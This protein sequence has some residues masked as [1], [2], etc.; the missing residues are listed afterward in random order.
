M[1]KILAFFSL[2]WLSVSVFAQQAQ[3]TGQVEGKQLYTLV[4]VYQFAPNSSMDFV[5]T[6]TMSPDGQFAFTADVPKSEIFVM[7]FTDGVR[8][9]RQQVMVLHP[10]DQLTMR[11]TSTY[12]G[13][14]LTEVKGSAEAAF[15]L[16]YQKQVKVFDEAMKG[17][18]DEFTNALTDLGRKAIQRDVEKFY[19][20]FQQ[21]IQQTL[22]TYA[23]C[24]GAVF[25]GLTE[26]GRSFDANKEM[27]TTLYNGTKDQYGYHPLLAELERKLQ[28]SVGL[29]NMAPDIELGDP[30]DKIIHLS[31][32]R[33]KYVLLDFWA[34]W[35]GPCRMENPNLVKAY[36]LYKDKNF[37]IFSVSL[38]ND[39]VKWQQAIEKDGLVW[40]YHVSSLMR[41]NCPVAMRY[42]VTSIPHSL[43]I[44]PQGKVIAIGL[45]GEAL[46]Q[47]LE[48]LL[49]K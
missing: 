28:N 49:G 48:S 23:S 20:N 47:K 41:W 30:A 43:L 15:M 6:A 13:L 3:V 9:T 34:S 46:L 42:N 31:D 11:L 33:G 4:K 19:V 38:D 37:A 16:E 10:G 26:F 44:D 35:C 40:P 7:Q 2:L 12:Q 29:G 45:R 18:E 1:K 5:T 21:G 24:L 17:F 14:Y 8:V 25:M 39:R 32:L 22:T 36:N 27:F